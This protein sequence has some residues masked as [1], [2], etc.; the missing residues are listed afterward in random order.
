MIINFNECLIDG[1][2]DKRNLVFSK[3]G[4]YKYPSK[5]MFIEFLKEYEDVDGEADIWSEED[6]PTGEVKIH[7]ELKYKVKNK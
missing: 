2:Y 6:I 1:E 4:K 5:R 3:S 7:I